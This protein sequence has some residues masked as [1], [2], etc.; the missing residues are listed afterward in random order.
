ML[1]M[2]MHISNPRTWSWIK[3]DQEGVQNHL[4]LQTSLGI[5]I[6][7]FAFLKRKGTATRKKA[8]LSHQ[9]LRAEVSFKSS[10]P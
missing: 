7:V 9:H 10:S 3:E 1:G 6:S 4:S 5:I 8:F 2:M